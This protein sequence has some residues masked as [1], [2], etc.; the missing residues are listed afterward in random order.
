MTK[1]QIC[2]CLFDCFFN[3]QTLSVSIHSRSVAD[4]VRSGYVLANICWHGSV[5]D[6]RDATRTSRMG[7]RTLK[8][9]TDELRIRCGR[10]MDTKVCKHFNE[11]SNSLIFL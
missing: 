2:R 3:L 6:E 11:K 5:M 10:A 7:I 4:P 1:K 8:T 9:L